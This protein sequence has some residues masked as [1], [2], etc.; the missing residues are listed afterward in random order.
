MLAGCG[1]IGSALND[2]DAAETGARIGRRGQPRA[3]RH[4][5]PRARVSR[6]RRRP[7]VSRER[8]R[9]A[10]RQPLHGSGA[11]N[12]A[13]PAVGRRRG[14]AAAAFLARGT[15]GAAAADADHAAR[16]RGRLERD[17]QVGRRPLGDV[18]DARSAARATR[19][20]SSSIAWTTTGRAASTTKASTCIRPRHPQTLLALR[21]Q[22]RAAR[23]SPRRARAAAHADPTRLQ[24]RE[25]DRP[26][27]DSS[28]TSNDLR[29][30]GGYW[31]DNG[32]EWYAGI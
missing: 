30:K 20:T 11:G 18:L 6:R 25:V 3:D 8:I 24:E 27:R 13:V 16:L 4:A 22:R 1:A 2:N 23:P 10:E 14:R 26:N 32:Y 29:R 31:E 28:E 17:R 21:P 15:A 19:A 5:R 12:F 9:G 7:G